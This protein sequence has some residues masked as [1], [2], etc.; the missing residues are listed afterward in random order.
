MQRGVSLFP[1]LS[2][3][4]ST[5]GILSFLAVIFTLLAEQPEP[6]QQPI[7]VRWVGAPPHVR[8][9]LIACR[10]DEAILH[11]PFGEKRRF[12]RRALEAEADR[13]RELR[14]H[15]LPQLGS[16]LNRRRLW[17]VM[18]QALP[19]DHDLRRSLALT[20]QRIET[21]NL[22]GRARQERREYYPV[23]LV[24]PDGLRTCDQVSFLLEHVTRL[25]VG[26][27]PML[28]HWQLPYVDL[29]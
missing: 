3:L 19:Q 22:S 14:D 24:Y 23:L 6:S 20:L 9:F 21:S 5:M 7:E 16:A 26:L 13:V 12:P 27:E 25:P 29:Q 8:P 11:D 1:F 17:Q 15:I 10:E 2:V 18:R 28:P 4:V